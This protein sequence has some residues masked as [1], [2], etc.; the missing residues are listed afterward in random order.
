MPFHQEEYFQNNGLKEG[1]YKSFHP[2]GHLSKE[3][4]YVNGVRHGKTKLYRQNK[5]YY[6]VDNVN[7]KLHGLYKIYSGKNK[8]YNNCKYPLYTLT[9]LLLHHL[10]TAFLNFG[11]LSNNKNILIIYIYSVIIT[12]FIQFINNLRCP[13]TLI[14]NN[15][16]NIKKNSYLRDFLYFANIKRNNLYVVYRIFSIIVSLYKLY[17]FNN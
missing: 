2:N 15:N 13:I 8:L 1:M 17:S 14:I 9:I 16:C 3:I 6:E 4:E 11:F 7:G 5:L 12:L 10:F